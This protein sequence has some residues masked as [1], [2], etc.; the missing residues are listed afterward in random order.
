MSSRRWIFTYFTDDDDLPNADLFVRSLRAHQDF[1][2]LALQLEQC[3]TTARL[4]L[5]GYVEWNKPIRLAALK[6]LSP[7]THWEPAKGSRQQ[8]V[9]YCSKDDTCYILDGTP[10]YR[11]IDSIL[12]DNTTQ[13]KRSDLLAASKSIAAGEWSLDDVH[14]E[15]PDLILKFSKGVRE[16]IAHRDQSSRRRLRPVVV[17]VLYGDA[18]TG[19]THAAFGDGS[20]VYILE[21]SN[22]NTIWWDGY[23][24]ESTLLIDDFYGWIRHNLLLRLLDK[25]PAKLDVKCS[26]TW[27]NWTKV[28]ITSNKHP[29]TWYSSSFPWAEDAA[30]RR[31]IHKIWAYKRT[32]R[33]SA[34]ECEETG[35]VERFDFGNSI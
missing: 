25:Y 31:R 3:P 12:T 1:R 29:S 16:L 9:A 21:N 20:D 30:L 33:G 23:N 17:E 15:R 32:D 5:Q 28:Y 34:R 26:S 24:G 13:G 27:A 22:S 10:A 35:E 8:C 11:E 14:R 19:K 4:H 18:G 2:G 7:T 6:K